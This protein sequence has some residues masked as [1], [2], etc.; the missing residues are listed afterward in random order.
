[1]KSKILKHTRNNGE[2]FYTAH[3]YTKVFFLWF[4]YYWNH[5]FLCDGIL[6]L[7][8]FGNP[9]YSDMDN[10]DSKEEAQLSLDFAIDKYIRKIEEKNG[11]FIKSTE[12]V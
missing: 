12:E 1:M 11:Q 2:V 6:Q 7:N 3:L 5:Y 4:F 10:F 8:I 9:L